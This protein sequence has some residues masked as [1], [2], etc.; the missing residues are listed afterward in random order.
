MEENK[1]YFCTHHSIWMTESKCNFKKC[2]KRQCTYLLDLRPTRVD[3][4]SELF[5]EVS[6]R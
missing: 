6:S 2:K 4:M 3:V 1:P 5:K